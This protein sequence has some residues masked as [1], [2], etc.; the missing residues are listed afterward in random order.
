M[1]Y[2]FAPGGT[3]YDRLARLL[4]GRKPNTT[5]IHQ[6]AIRDVEAFIDH[7]NTNAGIAKPV[8]D[9][10]IV[11]HGNASGWMAI[12]L[13]S[14]GV[15]PDGT[16]A[17]ETTYEVLEQSVAVNPHTVEIP[18]ALH[19]AQPNPIAFDVHILGCRIG[20]SQPFVQKLKDA[21]V[22]ARSVTAP[23]HF[24]FAGGI[25]SSRRRP[26]RY[27]SYENLS[28]S[29]VLTRPDRR[30]PAPARFSTKNEAVNAFD[31][32]GF[33]FIPPHAGGV[34]AAVP[35]AIWQREIPRSLRSRTRRRFVNLGQNVGRGLRRLRIKH[36][37]RN[38]GGSYTYTIS[39]VAAN[40]GNRAAREAMLR[41]SL[42][43][44]PKFQ[45]PPGHAFPVFVR[46]GYASVNDFVDGFSWTFNW[47][48][49]QQEL[50]C[51]GRRRVYTVVIPV[52]D[53]ANQNL[54]YNLYPVAGS[55][56]VQVTNLPRNDARL[57]LTV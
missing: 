34:G 24:H 37:F 42:G 56:L 4:L 27:G 12:D 48:R 5:V 14:S 11:S 21:F 51:V 44:H 8:G 53:P 54:F 33:T 16:P 19:H 45:A 57:F 30:R 9:L 22:R 49:Q 25:G 20:Q 39:G 3:G 47:R 28:Y 50:V 1:D 13:D 46:Y 31:N 36:Q 40:P 29:F 38:R 2:G 17:T 6:G 41:A 10:L 52:V 15:N 23:K 55:G 43:A 18:A 26:T 7:L 32:H 35:R